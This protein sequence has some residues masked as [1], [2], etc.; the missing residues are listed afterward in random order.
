MQNN[1][2]RVQKNTYEILILQEV[3]N[4]NFFFICFLNAAQKSQLAEL[5]TFCKTKQITLQVF[6]NKVFRKAVQNTKWSLLQNIIYSQLIIGYTP[7]KQQL[8]IQDMEQLATVLLSNSSIG[9]LFGFFSPMIITIKTLQLLKQYQTTL[10][11]DLQVLSSLKSKFTQL[12][13]FK[14]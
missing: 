10:L 14:E 2:K 9:F 3:L 13:F 5:K 12:L 8:S 4:S 11:Q 7:D 1:I 6:K